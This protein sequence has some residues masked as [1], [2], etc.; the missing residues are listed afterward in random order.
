MLSTPSWN[1]QTGDWVVPNTIWK[2]DQDI[3]E[4]APESWFA[5]GGGDYYVGL[6]FHFSP[7]NHPSGNGRVDGTIRFQPSTFSLARMQD[8]YN[9]WGVSAK[10]N[11]HLK[12]DCMNHWDWLPGIPFTTTARNSPYLLRN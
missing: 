10:Q 8:P 5:K 3:P 1:A 7:F 4:G 9:S 11:G 6:S 12:I 2:T